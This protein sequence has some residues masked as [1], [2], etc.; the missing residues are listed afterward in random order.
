MQYIINSVSVYNRQDCCMDRLYNSDV[1]ILDDSGNVVASRS[2]VDGH[3]SR[4]Y[5]LDFDNVAGRYVR[6]YKKV[7]GDINIAEVVVKGWSLSKSPTSSPSLGPTMSRVP[8]YSPVETPSVSPTLSS[9]PTGIEINLARLPGV[10]AQQSSTYNGLGPYRAIDGIK[11]D[12]T[13]NVGFTHTQCSDIPWWRADIGIGK[14][15]YV[16]VYNRND[17]VSSMCY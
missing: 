9:P 11:S 3:V 8:T 4:V 5:V 17:C 14:I 13:N 1:Q 7:F 15:K 16:K 2:I 6:F 10:V 12:G